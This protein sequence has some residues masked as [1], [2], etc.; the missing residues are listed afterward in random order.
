[1]RFA[2]AVLLYS[3]VAAAVLWSALWRS[4]RAIISTLPADISDALQFFWNGWWIRQSLGKGANPYYCDVVFAPKGAPLVFHCL[5]PLQS[6]L[7][8]TLGAVVSP[9][10]AYNLVVGIGL[11]VAGVGAYVLAMR[12]TD[13]ERGSLVAGLAFLLSPFVMSKAGAGHLNMLYVGVVPLFA[14]MLLRALDGG[15]KQAWQLAAAWIVVLASSLVNAVLAM[16]MAAIILA[17]RFLKRTPWTTVWRALRPT[18]IVSVP[19]AAAIGYYAIHYGLS[20]DA[21]R[22]YSNLPEPTSYVLPLTPTSAYAASIGRRIPVHRDLTRF[23]TAVYL[24]WLVFPL[25]VAGLWLRRGTPFGALF[26]VMLSVFLVISFG[27]VLLINRVPFRLAGIPLYLPF[28]AWRQIPILGSIWQSGR[29]LAIGYAAI[30]TGIA[31]LIA[32]R[33]RQTAW[34]LLAACAITMDYMPKL[35]AVSLPP[36]LPIGLLGKPGNV[37]DSRRTG[38]AMYYQSDYQRRLVGGYLCRSPRSLLEEYRSI[39]GMGCLF[40]GA[41]CTEQSARHAASELSVAYIFTSPQDSRGE[42]F[43]AFGFKRL[44]SDGHTDVWEVL[45]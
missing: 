26:A 12:V 3:A 24:G 39:D 43:R 37:L 10:T 11:V 32:S 23:D 44:Y 21:E 19:I 22:R 2:R 29:Y 5:D 7:M 33:R 6:G 31:M 27:Q 45:P 1:M 28:V 42:S 20:A 8:A 41:T 36:P 38:L 15:R 25:G 13:N 35:S 16:N 18:A 14:A 9:W 30:A 4:E 40:F 34:A 17:W